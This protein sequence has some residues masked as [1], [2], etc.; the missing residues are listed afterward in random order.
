MLTKDQAIQAMNEGKKVRHRSFT[1]DEWMK[2]AEHRVYRYEF[3]DGC[4]SKCGDFWETRTH[5][6]WLID[7]EIVNE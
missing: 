7:W 4:I 6:N 2:K 5:E 1:D 3:E